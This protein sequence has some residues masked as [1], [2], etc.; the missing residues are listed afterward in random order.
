MLGDWDYINTA[1]DRLLA[2]TD[3]DIT[4]IANEY[5]GEN[6][7]SV[8]IYRRSLDAEPIDDELTQFS[9]E[10]LAM[11]QQAL[12]ELESMPTES[13]VGALE[14]MRMQSTQVPAE[15][16][17]VFDYLLRKL[18]EKVQGAEK[19]DEPKQIELEP[20][21]EIVNE[22]VEVEPLE[23]PVEIEQPQE[24][25]LTPQQQ[26]EADQFF[27]NIAP[28]ELTDL[29]RMYTSL[30]GVSSSVPAKDQPVVQF[31]IAKLAVRIKELQ[32]QENK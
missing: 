16:K 24:L 25:V 12:S 23:E 1:S 30:Q 14:N 6:N 21:D 7:S 9:P 27:A 2:V 22:I 5:F 17:P 8:A 32:E 29:V 10:Q 19:V 28:M 4:R 20:V 11:V 18:E 31:I 26:A 3:A 15:I 13:L